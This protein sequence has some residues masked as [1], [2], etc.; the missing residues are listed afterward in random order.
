MPIILPLLM[1]FGGGMPFCYFKFSFVNLAG[2]ICKELHCIYFL[3]YNAAFHYILLPFFNPSICISSVRA[4]VAGLISGAGVVEGS[5]CCWESATWGLW[6][7][8]VSPLR[9]FLSENPDLRLCSFPAISTLHH[10][11]QNLRGVGRRVEPRAC[12][13]LSS[14]L[15]AD[16]ITRV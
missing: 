15:E 9:Y 2:P 8:Y 12:T 10:P 11:F 14:L 6:F 7:V 16:G 13:L 5:N 4:T 1:I 3:V